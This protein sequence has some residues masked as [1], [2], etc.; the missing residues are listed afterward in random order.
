MSLVCSH[1]SP[2]LPFLSPQKTLCHQ[3]E[4]VR[5]DVEQDWGRGLSSVRE[6]REE[7]K[8]GRRE[9]VVSHAGC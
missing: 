7:G 1:I 2:S 5:I 9:G 3:S 8:E 6:V 4:E